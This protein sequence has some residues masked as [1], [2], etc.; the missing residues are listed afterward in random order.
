MADRLML[1][2]SLNLHL[3]LKLSRRIGPAIALPE[4][5]ESIVVLAA[6]KSSTKLAAAAR[7]LV[8]Q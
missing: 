5:P 7:Q 2:K 1:A 4:P 6:G 8:K 3:L